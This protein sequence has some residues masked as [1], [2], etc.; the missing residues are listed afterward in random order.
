[1]VNWTCTVKY[2]ILRRCHCGINRLESGLNSST[3][4]VEL[5]PG[6]LNGNQ[7]DT[8]FIG[9][10]IGAIGLAAVLILFP[11]LIPILLAAGVDAGEGAAVDTAAGA[12]T[13]AAAG[14]EPG[15]IT[16]AKSVMDNPNVDEDTLEKA[17]QILYWNK[18]L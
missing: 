10:L 15:Y 9:Y 1:M 5:P 11:E 7:P 16:W 18:M 3:G 8:Q 13:D 14:A 17:E 6:T 12:V 4:G 2:W